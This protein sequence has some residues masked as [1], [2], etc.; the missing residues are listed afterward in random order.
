MVL[1]F[2]AGLVFTWIYER[3]NNLWAIGI[4]HGILGAVAYYV[5]LGHDPG[6]E[7]IGLLNHARI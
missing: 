7:I 4:V 1:T 3:H 5:V 6:A 2:V